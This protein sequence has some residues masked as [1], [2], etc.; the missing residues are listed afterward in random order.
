[1]PESKGLRHYFGGPF[2]PLLVPRRSM[3]ATAP[4]FLTGRLQRCVGIRESQTCTRPE[5]Q[6]ASS[7][8]GWRADCR[9]WALWFEDVRGAARPSR[10]RQVDDQTSE[11]MPKRPPSRL[12]STPRRTCCLPRAWRRRAHHL[13]LPHLQRNGAGDS[14]TLDQT[15]LTGRVGNP[16]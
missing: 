9:W 14:A 8:L 15:K 13:A 4:P 7:C 12:P 16:I 1:M 11:P 3:G 6:C 5:A 10:R 2:H